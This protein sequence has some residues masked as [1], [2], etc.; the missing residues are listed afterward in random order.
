[1]HIEVVKAAAE[2]TREAVS[3]APSVMGASPLNAPDLVT[4]FLDKVARK[5][6]ELQKA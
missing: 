3:K 6:D 4:A 5:L 1:M 2:I